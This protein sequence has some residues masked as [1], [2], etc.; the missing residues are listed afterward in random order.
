MTTGP[1]FPG[2]YHLS[3]YVGDAFERSIQL[4]DSAGVVLDITGMSWA[5][6]IRTLKGRI[7]VASF[8]IAVDVPT[9]TL[10]LTLTAAQTAALPIGRDLVWD[11]E[12]ATED[13]TWL[14]GVVSPTR[15]VT[16]V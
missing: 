13:K 16:R 14:Y 7:L 12:E 9:A 6:Q 2:V 11:L 15:D 8:T 5:A 4:L 10:T 1:S 3:I